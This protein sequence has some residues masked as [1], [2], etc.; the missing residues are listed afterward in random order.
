MKHYAFRRERNR[1]HAKMTR[2]RK[3]SFIAAIEKTIEELESSNKRMNDVLADVIYSQKLSTHAEILVSSETKKIVNIDDKVLP[4][5]GVTPSSSPT[6]IPRNT[7]RNS[8]PDLMPALPISSSKKSAINTGMMQME[9]VHEKD[10]DLPI[11][12]LHLPPKKRVCH[13]FSL[14]Y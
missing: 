10:H 7:L 12:E 2:D 3:K 13:G 5:P 8:I 9:H 4:L 14:P 6:M 1:M 11:K